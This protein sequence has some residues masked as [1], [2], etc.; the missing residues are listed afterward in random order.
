[1]NGT[2]D[3]ISLD[4]TSAKVSVGTIAPALPAGW[5]TTDTIHAIP[6][7]LDTKTSGFGFGTIGVNTR[8]ARKT[9]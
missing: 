4:N 8:P 3:E 1:V 6:L 2:R 7:V 9:A 5:E